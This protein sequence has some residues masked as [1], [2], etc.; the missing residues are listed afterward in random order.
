MGFLDRLFGRKGGTE[1]APGKEEE[2][3]ADVPC[4]H[5]SLVAHWD[6]PG[7]MGK[8]DAVS[9]YIC[10]SCG[11]RF[12]GDQG[13][14]LMAQA[15]RRPVYPSQT[16]SVPVRRIRKLITADIRAAESPPQRRRKPNPA[17][18][19]NLAISGDGSG[20]EPNLIAP[21]TLAR[22]TV[23][24]IT[25]ATNM[26]PDTRTTRDENPSSPSAL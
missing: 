23:P 10:E 22:R 12:S 15:A 21:A 17:C 11:E 19:R 8:T 3:I 4:P 14:R 7:A 13:Q 6:D 25:M 20:V 9:Y 18:G 16:G 1:T 26:M 24:P 2:W 5:G